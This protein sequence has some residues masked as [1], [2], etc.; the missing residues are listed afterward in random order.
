[1]YRSFSK[2]LSMSTDYCRHVEKLL[3]LGKE[4]ERD[5]LEIPGAHT[6]KGIVFVSLQEWKYLLNTLVTKK[7]LEKN[8]A[9]WS[10]MT[11][12]LDCRF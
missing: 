7:K 10:G 9:L 11:L 12:V 6:V 3:N 4:L 1:M 2:S 8:I 5:S